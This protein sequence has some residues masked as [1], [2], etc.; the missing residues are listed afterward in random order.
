[1]MPSRLVLGATLHAC[2]EI[3]PAGIVSPE[4][5]GPQRVGRAVELKVRTGKVLA[6]GHIWEADNVPGVCNGTRAVIKLEYCEMPYQMDTMR[7]GR[8]ASVFTT[9]IES[10]LNLFL[11]R[12]T[13]PQIR[14]PV[15][16][17][18]KAIAFDR[19]DAASRSSWTTRWSP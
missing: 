11:P 4:S 19:C 14:N 12:E 13:F 9:Q 2:D 8:E 18:S 15:K 3:F 7:R 5:T 1:M 16:L 6:I 10:F 17:H